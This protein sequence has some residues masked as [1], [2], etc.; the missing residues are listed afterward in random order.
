MEPKII[1]TNV[2]DLIVES[3][4]VI[5]HA[6]KGEVWDRDH[7]RIVEIVTYGN[8]VDITIKLKGFGSFNKENV[9]TMIEGQLELE[10]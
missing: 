1:H 9:R 4:D 6:R 5:E 3:V 2:G 8:Y 10:E 7:T